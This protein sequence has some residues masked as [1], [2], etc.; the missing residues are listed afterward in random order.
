MNATNPAVASALLVLAIGSSA[1]A[2]GQVLLF[3]TF[4]VEPQGW[5]SANLDPTWDGWRSDGGN[6]GG[7]FVLNS[8]GSVHSDPRVERVVAGL[9]IGRTYRVEGEYRD[10]YDYCPQPTAISFRVDIN[11]TTVFAGPKENQWRQF[12]GEWVADS[13]H[14]LLVIRAETDGT[15]CDAAIDNIRITEVIPCLADINGSNDVDGVDLAAVL[16]A[17]GTSGQGFYNTDITND[18]IVDGADLAF[19][20]SGWGPCP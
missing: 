11:G 16:G 12:W 1:Q 2:G 17:W 5:T 19:V 10:Y 6:P 8:G 4:D 7:C 18:G 3:E 14:A 20:L 13:S 9:E 15:D